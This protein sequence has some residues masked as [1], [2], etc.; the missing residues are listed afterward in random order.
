[1]FYLLV[2]SS[3]H[4]AEHFKW[5]NDYVMNVAE[6]DGQHRHFISILDRVYD[7]IL[8]QTPNEVKGALLDDLVNYALIHFGTEERYFDE[9]NY[10]G[11]AEHKAAHKELLDKVL[12]FQSEF[13]EKKKD[14][15]LE[16]IDFLED[17]LVN[18]LMTMDKKYVDC[19]HEHGLS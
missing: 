16:L 6:I 4:M 17:W 15:S 13:K 10:S 8:N 7:T 5:T 19:F 2:L 18:H 14:I 1:M 9:F 3:K 12:S 11:A